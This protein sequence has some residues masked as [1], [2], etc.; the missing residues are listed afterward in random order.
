[1][2]V[3]MRL[4][5]GTILARILP[6]YYAAPWEVTSIAIQ[7]SG[8]FIFLYFDRA[9]TCASNRVEVKK[10]EMVRDRTSPSS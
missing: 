5:Y 8:G 2:Q 1:M 6:R 7:C 10:E 9:A 4:V 3:P